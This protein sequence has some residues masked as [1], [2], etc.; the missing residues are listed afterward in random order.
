MHLELVRMTPVHLS[1]SSPGEPNE[2]APGSDNRASVVA[3]NARVLIVEDESLVAMNIEQTLVEAGF[4][5]IGIVD[6]EE[7]AIEAAQRLKPDIVL[8]DITLREGNGVAAAAEIYRMLKL[9]VLFL[10]GNTDMRTL[11]AIQRVPSRGLIRKPFV[12]ERL[13]AHVRD[14]IARNS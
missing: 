14:A 8:M 4:H 2:G 11:E 9:P 12:S 13:A 7:D 1:A 3:E 6:T 5:V 10:T